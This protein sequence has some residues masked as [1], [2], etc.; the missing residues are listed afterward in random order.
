MPRAYVQL[1]HTSIL[2]Y[3][4]PV[5]LLP[6]CNQASARYFYSMLTTYLTI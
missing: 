1:E 2:T 3:F 4:R 5:Y 6:T